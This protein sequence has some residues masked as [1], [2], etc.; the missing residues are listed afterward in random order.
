MK[1][2]VDPNVDGDN[3]T[4]GIVCTWLEHIDYLP[5]HQA[6]HRIRVGMSEGRPFIQY[7]VWRPDTFT[8][9]MGWGKGGKAFLSHHTIQQEFVQTVFS[10]IQSYELHEVRE[11]FTYEGRR[12]Y[13]PHIDLGALW[14]AAEHTVTRPKVATGDE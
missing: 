5:Y 4:V 13:G 9:E 3:I 7:Q 8:S 11:G 1:I 2:T 6:E 12:I 14:E 10:L